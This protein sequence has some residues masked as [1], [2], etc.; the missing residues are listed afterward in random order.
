MKCEEFE[1]IL[2]LRFAKIVAPQI[3][4]KAKFFEEM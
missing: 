4:A 3:Y 2:H 1:K